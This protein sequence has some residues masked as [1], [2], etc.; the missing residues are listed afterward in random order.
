MFRFILKMVIFS[1]TMSLSVLGYSGG[2]GSA[3]QPWQIANINDFNQLIHSPGTWADHFILTDNMDL[4]GVVYEK[5]PIAPDIDDA[6]YDFQG[7]VFTGELDGNGFTISNLTITNTTGGDFLGLFG[8]IQY[9]RITNLHLDSVTIKVTGYDS[10]NY[11]AE[12]IGGLTGWQ[13]YGFVSNCSVSGTVGTEAGWLLY[14]GNVGG[15]VGEINGLHSGDLVMENCSSSATVNGGSNVGCLA[16]TAWNCY[17]IKCFSDG[18]VMG[19][20]Y[21]GGLV[22]NAAARIEQCYNTA[23][24]TGYYDEYNSSQ[25]I[26]GLVGHT[27]G[28]IYEC[29]NRGAIHITKG[30]YVGGLA[31]K[32]NWH[33]TRSYN[34]GSIIVENS[35]NG[36]IGGLA[37][38]VNEGVT[39][40]SDSFWDTQASGQQSSAGGGTPSN[41]SDMQQQQTYTNA[42]WDFNS[43]WKIFPHYYPVFIWEPDPVIDYSGGQG[44][45]DDPWQITSAQ[46]W[47]LLTN[48]PQHWS[49]HFILM[50]NIDFQ[51]QSILPVGDSHYEEFFDEFGNPYV[52]RVDYPFAGVMNGNG[53]ILKNLS[54][55]RD[56]GLTEFAGLF[57]SN[58]GDINQ[59]GLENVVISDYYNTGALVGFNL[60]AISECYATG[61][62][63]YG[64]YLGGL[65]GVNDPGAIIN[66]CYSLVAVSG[67]NFIGGLVGLNQP[68]G[69]ISNCLAAGAVTGETY[70]GGLIGY[71]EGYYYGCFYDY[72]TSGQ[73]DFSGI[74]LPTSQLQDITPYLDAGWDFAPIEEDGTPAVWTIN[75]DHYPILVWQTRLPARYSGGEGTAADP[76]K[77]ATAQDLIDLGQTTADYD[78]HFQQIANIDLSQYSFTQ[79]VIAPYLM[80]S[81]DKFDFAGVYDGG[82]YRILN[83]TINAP[84]QYYVGL[85]GRIIAGSKIKNLR[86]DSVNITGDWYA[87]GLCGGNGDWDSSGGGLI[88]GCLVNGSIVSVSDSAGGLCGF[89][90][91]VI[92][93][94]GS[95]QGSVI[96]P[97][98][99][100]GLC[101]YNNGTIDQCFSAMTVGDGWY[102]G[103]L[104]GYN[105]GLLSQS[106]ATGAVN[107]SGNYVGGFCSLNDGTIS[108]CYST[109][110]VTGGGATGGFCGVNNITIEGCFWDIQTSG[111]DSSAGGEGLE[112]Q[113][114]QQEQ[115]YLDANWNFQTIWTIN[116]NDYPR[117]AW[118]SAMTNRYGGGDGSESSPYEIWTVSHLL[119][120][121]Q[122]PGDWDMA[123]ILMAD[124]DLTGHIF[125]QAVIA[126]DT[127]PADYD[128]QGTLFT[129]RFEGNGKTISHL[130]IVSNQGVDFVGLFGCVNNARIGNLILSNASITLNGYNSSGGT[131]VYV[132]VLAGQTQYS[133]IENC[134]SSGQIVT[135]T[136]PSSGDTASLVGGLIGHAYANY[137]WE[138]SIDRCFSSVAVTAGSTTGGLVGGQLNCT[139]RQSGSQ[140]AVSGQWLIGGLVGDSA[141]IIEQCYSVSPVTDATGGYYVGGLV[142]ASFGGVY[143]SYSAG[144]VFTTLLSRHVG[145][146]IGQASGYLERCY[147]TSRLYMENGSIDVGSLIGYNYD[148]RVATDGCFW[149]QAFSGY[150]TSDGGQEIS[151]LEMLNPATFQLAGWD[152]APAEEDGTPA[153]WKSLPNEAPML[154][155]QSYEKMDQQVFYLLS[156]CWLQTEVS[157]TPCAQPDLTGDGV[158]DASDLAWLA[159]NWLTTIRQ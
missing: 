150:P 36:F 56:N 145:G 24:I 152:Y 115:T 138:L 3:D 22:G 15:L 65:V 35:D 43:V 94:C 77:I 159:G 14:V 54:I 29:Y 23:S 92:E 1:L 67:W 6:Q 57:S 126:P 147:S 156:Q 129:G 60:G 155:W 72:E 37:G 75:P 42:N 130:K 18:Q 84:D 93:K 62:I 66:N 9:A 143:D 134:S 44:T 8:K 34:A 20:S 151:A 74:G 121:S 40:I 63:D 59:L 41:T 83:L 117:L 140:G 52:A 58:T 53:H 105:Y 122:T 26:G 90:Q 97:N 69:G 70:A 114:M 76:Y 106:F 101:G 154:T 32:T 2:N 111:Q 61:A 144:A 81:S 7:D 85:F 38:Q 108:Q 96:S 46:D 87:G 141:G 158:V 131:S 80:N 153:I 98:T 89:N 13:D 51:G 136:T 116:P 125:D 28:D 21:V 118:L 31:G 104:C 10:G 157:G 50:N 107:G 33:I 120:L 64:D 49:S 132:G 142:G 124:L 137:W 82:G 86:L 123:F 68:N 91:G 95:T 11:G 30:D 149:S 78:K 135:G 88:S 109:G 47:I 128:F 146:L 48:S 4:S 133:I 5:A 148:D 19:H 71:N 17:L 12:F 99:S 113:F 102:I 103:G 45:A 55:Y 73:N 16:G 127:T 110:S 100:G 112:T 139:I 25:H 39:T 79:A 27:H 119:D